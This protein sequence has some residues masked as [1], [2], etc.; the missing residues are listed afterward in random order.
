MNERARLCPAMGL[1]EADDDID[2]FVL[3]APRVL[4]HGVGL[5]DSGRGAE[6]H[7]QPARSLPTERG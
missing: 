2:A 7:F 5:A 4:Q 6:E 3:E 1:D